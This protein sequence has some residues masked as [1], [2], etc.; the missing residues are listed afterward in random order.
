[1]GTVEGDTMEMEMVVEMVEEIELDCD[2]R[3]CKS[4]ESDEGGREAAK[5]EETVFLRCGSC[6]F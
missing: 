4:E 2:I 5:G 1:M 6:G 3:M